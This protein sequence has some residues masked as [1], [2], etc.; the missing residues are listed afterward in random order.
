M[1]MIGGRVLPVLKDDHSIVQLR[2]LLQFPRAS[3]IAAR[4][5]RGLACFNPLFRGRDGDTFWP[6][7][8][9]GS[10]AGS[11]MAGSAS[12]PSDCPVSP[13]PLGNEFAIRA[14]TR[15]VTRNYHDRLA[16]Y[17]SRRCWRPRGGFL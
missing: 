11:A 16:L 9:L 12:T 2:S 13:T 8:G 10:A 5:S 4:L 15:R 17:A 14:R 7:T 6:G 3:R 1:G